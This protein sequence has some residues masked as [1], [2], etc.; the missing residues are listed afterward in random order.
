MR[1]SALMKKFVIGMLFIVLM[2]A[3]CAGI[4]VPIEGVFPCRMQFEGRAEIK[5]LS[6][7][8]TGAAQITST[9]AGVA[10][11]Y[12]PGGLAAFTI[13]MHDGDVKILDMW[14]RTIKTYSIPLK[15]CIGFLAGV[16]YEGPYLYRRSMEKGMQIT[17]PWGNI[18]LDQALLP[19]EIHVDTGHVLDLLFTPEHEGIHLLI[20]HGSDKL[21]L[22]IQILEGGRWRYAQDNL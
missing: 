2:A 17:Y 12:G 13:D 3:G 22:Q 9:S 21:D 1:Y 8:L 7:P 16:P 5:G 6:I 4:Q 10:Q 18:R 19:R 15:D 11:V 20:N 14:G